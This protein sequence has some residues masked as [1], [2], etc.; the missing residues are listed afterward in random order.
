LLWGRKDKP[1]DKEQTGSKVHRQSLQ[2]NL[3]KQE[4]GQKQHSLQIKQKRITFTLKLETKYSFIQFR[5]YRPQYWAE[6]K[7]SS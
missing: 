6:R 3:R 5:N 4:K 2:H 7:K 1:Y